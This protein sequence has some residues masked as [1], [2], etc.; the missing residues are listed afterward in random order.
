MVPSDPEYFLISTVLMQN[1][2][3]LIGFKTGKIRDR[4]D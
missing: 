4:L 2:M 1:L 3:I